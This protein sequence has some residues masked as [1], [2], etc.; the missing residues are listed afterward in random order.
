MKSIL[1]MTVLLTFITTVFTENKPYIIDGRYNAETKNI[2]INVGYTGGCAEHKF[3]LML[4]TAR[5]IFPGRHDVELIDFTTND[6]CDA[7][8]QRKILI[9]LYEAGLDDSYFVGSSIMIHGDKNSKVLI[10][11]PI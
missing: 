7:L 1:T 5:K 4:S 10:T 2:E 11:L 6:Y 8:I 3:K 9:G